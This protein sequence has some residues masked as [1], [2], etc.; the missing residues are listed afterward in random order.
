MKELVAHTNPKSVVT[1]S[2]KTIRTNLLF[3]SVDEK[4][5]RILITSANPV[6]GKSYISANLAITFAQNDQKVLL[7]DC[8]LRK[9]RLHEVFNLNNDIGLSNLLLENDRVIKKY[10]KETEIENLDILTMGVIPPNPSELLGSKK[11]INFLDKAE[12]EYDIVIVDSPPVN[13]VSD[14]LAVASKVNAVLLVATHA[15]TKN[16]EL[17]EAIKHIKNVGGRLAGIVINQKKINKKAYYGKY[18]QY[19]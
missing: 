14:A 1:E 16:H 6:E 5:K 9:G 15:K 3:S 17:D 8:D 13:R 4:L 2:L 10:I 11:F 18:Y 19:Y 7:V 12:K